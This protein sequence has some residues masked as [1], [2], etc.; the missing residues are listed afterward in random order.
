MRIERAGYECGKDQRNLPMDGERL[1]LRGKDIDKRNF[2]DVGGQGSNQCHFRCFFFRFRVKPT[3]VLHV[4][5]R[6]KVIFVCPKDEY[7]ILWTYN[8]QVFENCSNPGENGNAVNILY[9]CSFKDPYN[10]PSPKTTDL[11][12]MNLWSPLIPSDPLNRSFPGF[13]STAATSMPYRRPRPSTKQILPR[14]SRDTTK[15][16]ASREEG[17]TFTLLINEFA[18]STGTPSFQRNRPVYFT[19]KMR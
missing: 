11:S 5:Q 15:R 12:E 10:T 13:P 2:S 3:A 8:K 6:D 19:G 4:E 9:R 1:D 17:E 16:F 14:I 18:W 7:F